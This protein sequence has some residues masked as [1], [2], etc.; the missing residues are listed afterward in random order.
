LKIGDLFRS[1]VDEQNHEV[2]IGMIPFILT[3]L[4]S[5]IVILPVFGG[6]TITPPCLFPIDKIDPVLRKSDL[7]I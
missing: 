6:P 2:A 5:C 3:A 4:P 7:R 1:L